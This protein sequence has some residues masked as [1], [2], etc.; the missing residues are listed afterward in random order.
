MILH[1]NRLPADD[2]HE[3]SCL[4]CY[5]CKSGKNFNCRVLQIIAGALRVKI[6]KC[7]FDSSKI[8]TANLNNVHATFLNPY[9]ADIFSPNLSSA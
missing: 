1:E 2:S 9:P 8:C 5:F 7:M 3:I 6:N 4:I